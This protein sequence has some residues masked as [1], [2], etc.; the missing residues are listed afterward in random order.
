M[1]PIFLVEENF[2][3]IADRIFLA[4]VWVENFDEIALSC[5][6]KEMEANLCFLHFWQKF[7]MATI[8]GKS[9]SFWKLPRVHCL[10]ILCVE[11]FTEIAL[12]R[13]V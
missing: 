10:D 3:K 1:D 4:T 8:F 13:K 5:T 6:V 11:N 2:L 7:K 9:K 12:S